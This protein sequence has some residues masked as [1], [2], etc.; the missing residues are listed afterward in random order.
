[1]PIEGEPRA[2]VNACKAIDAFMATTKM[3]ELLV[4]A[5]PGVLIPPKATTWYINKIADLK[6]AFV[7]QGLHFI[8]EG[9]PD[10]GW[11]N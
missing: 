7:G 6:T 3:P 5:D 10:A 11:R 9:Q 4:Y 8:Q 1:M 2:T